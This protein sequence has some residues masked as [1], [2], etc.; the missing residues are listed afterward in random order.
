MALPALIPEP[1]SRQR[2]TAA[3]VSNEARGQL[4]GSLG[5][6]WHLNRGCDKAVSL[7]GR[8]NSAVLGPKPLLALLAGLAG[9]RVAGYLGGA[10]A[11]TTGSLFTSGPVPLLL[12]LCLPPRWF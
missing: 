2:S 6:N 1:S 8:L 11:P 7:K 4:E 9:P 12:L 10:L 3:L 5:V